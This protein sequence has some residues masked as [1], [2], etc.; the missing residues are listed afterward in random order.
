MIAP[1]HTSEQ[2]SDPSP[3]KHRLINSPHF[4]LHPL[5]PLTHSST[6]P[7]S[8]HPPPHQSSASTYPPTIIRPLR[9]STYSDG[10]QHSSPSCS[11][12]YS[13][14]YCWKKLKILTL[15]NSYH[16][17][18]H[19]PCLPWVRHAFIQLRDQPSTNP[20]GILGHPTETWLFAANSA[21]CMP[22]APPSLDAD[23]VLWKRGAQTAVVLKSL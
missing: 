18:S 21:Q 22:K 15:A 20:P 13:E 12:R 4:P 16:Q 7:L 11:S 17:P 5:Q 3:S 9:H 1:A 8:A 10:P 6:Q 19:F 23:T 2:E 14:F